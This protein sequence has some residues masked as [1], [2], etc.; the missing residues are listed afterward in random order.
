MIK[1]IKIINDDII[2]FGDKFCYTEDR[3][4]YG[5][6]YEPITKDEIAEEIA[7]T[8][9]EDIDTYNMNDIEDNKGYVMSS[10]GHSNGETTDF[11][12]KIGNHIYICSFVDCRGGWMD[13]SI[14]Y[15]IDTNE[16]EIDKKYEEAIVSDEDDKII[17]EYAMKHYY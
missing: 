6:T 7:N 5:R 12:M 8:A 17:S 9:S 4:K 3:Y 10:C 16:F 2:Q 15:N 13:I 1:E 14:A 11:F